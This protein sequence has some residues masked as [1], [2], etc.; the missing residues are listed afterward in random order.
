MGAVVFF[1]SN[2]SRHVTGQYIAIDGGT[3]SV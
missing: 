1:A 2:A 3:T